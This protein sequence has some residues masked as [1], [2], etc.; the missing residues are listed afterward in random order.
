[1]AAGNVLA[2]VDIQNPKT[3][4]DFY[5]RGLERESAKD[6][7]EALAD[8]QIAGLLEPQF[9]DA[10]FSLSSLCAKTK[11]YRGAIA[12]LTASLKARP[13]DYSA[14]FN[15]GLYHEHLGEY[16]DAIADYTLALAEDADFSHHVN[17]PEVCRA[18]AYHYR[19]R[20]YQWHKQEC[21]KAVD[22]YTEALRLDPGIEMVRYRRA[23]AFHD[24]KEYAKAH[25]DFGAA[26]EVDPDY[27]NLLNAWAWQLATCPVAK[28]RDGQLDLELAKKTKDMD[29]LAAAY[30]ETGAFEE[31]VASQKRAIELLERQPEPSEEK[32]MESR[33]ERRM[34]MQTR[35]AAYEGGRPYRDE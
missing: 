5:E 22:D 25:A 13:K 2:Q 16:D 23:R 1:M 3:A 6:F 33:K 18:H 26:R 15:R 28:Y 34:Q 7:A 14:L 8:Y 27:P 10:H 11:D 35:L 32:A 12:A 31:A 20:V 4:R 29:T 17:P 30:A 21:A 24:L 19:G 9:F